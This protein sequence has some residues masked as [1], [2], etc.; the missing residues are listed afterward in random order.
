M[1]IDI[2]SSVPGQWFSIAQ[3]EK[4]CTSHI[5]SLSNGQIHE[6]V[7]F[8]HQS[9]GL[10]KHMDTFNNIISLLKVTERPFFVPVTNGDFDSQA[11]PSRY[12]VSD[13]SKS[14]IC[15]FSFPFIHRCFSPL[16][17]AM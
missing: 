3:I 9:D 12:S 16:S 2:A 11:N 4:L 15:T 14:N 5:Q 6:I 8:L 7:M 13:Q 10:S 17:C 1:V